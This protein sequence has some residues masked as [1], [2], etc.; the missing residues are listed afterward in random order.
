M[1]RLVV[2][3]SPFFID[4]KRRRISHE[5]ENNVCSSPLTEEKLLPAHETLRSRTNRQIGK[6][7]KKHFLKNCRTLCTQVPYSK[8]HKFRNKNAEFFL[9]TKMEK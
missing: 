5:N 2:A 1:A 7:K 3:N 8:N 4:P 6:E 9:N